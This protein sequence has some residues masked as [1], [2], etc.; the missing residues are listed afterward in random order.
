MLER[1]G[2]TS[3]KLIMVDKGALDCTIKARIQTAIYRSN[4]LSKGNIPW[5]EL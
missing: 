3:G 2:V 1:L 4:D 5:G